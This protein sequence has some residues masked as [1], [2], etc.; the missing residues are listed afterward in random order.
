MMDS[1]TQIPHD[2]LQP[3]IVLEPLHL[4]LLSKN[5][6]RK[7]VRSTTIFKRKLIEEHSKVPLSSDL[8]RRVVK[9]YVNTLT[10]TE[11]QKYSKIV[12]YESHCKTKPVML[13]PGKSKNSVARSGGGQKSCKKKKSVPLMISKASL[14][15]FNATIGQVKR[16]LNKTCYIEIKPFPSSYC[17]VN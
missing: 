3:K 12:D 13:L 14:K 2:V 9:K 8:G 16:F 17:L 5:D 6:Q 10:L 7:A 15:K 11:S 4:G 1:T